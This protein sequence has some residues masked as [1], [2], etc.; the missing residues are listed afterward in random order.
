M[1]A[2]MRDR[3]DYFGIRTPDR[4]AIIKAHLEEEGPV[5]LEELDA[6]VREAWDFPK[7]EMHYFAQ[8]LIARNVKRLELSDLALIEF[9]ITHNSWWDSVDELAIRCAGPLLRAHPGAIHRASE[10]WMASDDLW[11]NRTALIF[12][13]KYKAF[14]DVELLFANIDRLAGHKDFFIR[15]AIGWSLRE[16]AKTDPDAVVAFVRSRKLDP[17]SEREAMKHLR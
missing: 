2:Y 16:F 11:L 12:Q 6:I 5:P 4:R 17:L 9:G 15:K 14:T 7:R 1:K 8:E 10:R 3:F 13:I